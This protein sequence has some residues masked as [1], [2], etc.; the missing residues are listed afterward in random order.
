[1]VWEC[2]I[3]GRVLARKLSWVAGGHSVRVRWESHS[4][5]RPVRVEGAEPGVHTQFYSGLA[6]AGRTV[7]PGPGAEVVIEYDVSTGADQPG[8]PVLRVTPL[9]L[10]AVSSDAEEASR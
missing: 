4:C 10:R 1:M 2:P 7:E 6:V 5:E 9:A 3:W 8:V